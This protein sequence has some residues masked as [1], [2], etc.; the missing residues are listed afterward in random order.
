MTERVRVLIA[1]VVLLVSHIRFRRGD[2][3][4]AQIRSAE[5]V[6]VK[7]GAETFLEVFVVSSL[8]PAF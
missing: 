7:A 5:E 6:T 3:V 2:H 1:I 8:T 4:S